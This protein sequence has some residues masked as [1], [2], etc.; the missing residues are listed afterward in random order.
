MNTFT[1][2]DTSFHELVLNERT[3]ACLKDRNERH[4]VEDLI[5][6][7]ENVDTVEK[8]RILFTNVEITNYV[9]QKECSIKDY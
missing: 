8:L 4:C 3:L 1:S 7:L 2:I 5:F 9:F 6:L